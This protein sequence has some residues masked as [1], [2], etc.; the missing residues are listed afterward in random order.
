MPYCRNCGATVEGDARYCP[1]CGDLLEDDAGSGAQHDEWGAREEQG[2]QHRGFEDRSSD[3]R[4]DRRTRQDRPSPGYPRPP[5]RDDTDV[6]GARIVAQVI[7]NVVMIVLFLGFLIVSSGVDGVVGNEAGA[8]LSLLLTLAAFA[9]VIFYHFFLEGYWD[10]YT[11]GK[12]LMGIKV[13]KETGEPCTYGSA[14]L[15]NLLEII[16]GFFY[17]AVGFVAMAASDKRQRIG[18]RAA[19]TVVVRE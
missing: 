9:S 8:G 4:P 12:K 15:R 16:D 19:G 14:L 17:Y 10:G 5:D 3:R 13:V 1:E 6:I 11:V 7:D 18:D 2:A